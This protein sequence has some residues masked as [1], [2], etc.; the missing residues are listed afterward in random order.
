MKYE[1]VKVTIT[2]QAQPCTHDALPTMNFCEGH[3][4]WAEEIERQAKK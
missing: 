4:A 2:C 3:Q 1:G